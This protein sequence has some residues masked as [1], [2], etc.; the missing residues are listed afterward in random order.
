MTVYRCTTDEC[1]EHFATWSEATQ[2]VDDTGHAFTGVPE[3]ERPWLEVAYRVHVAVRIGERRDE[4]VKAALE[5]AGFAVGRVEALKS[6]VV[7]VGSSGMTR[8]EAERIA[9][10]QNAAEAVDTGDTE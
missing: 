7:G 2:H 8:D 5:D 10:E 4:R 3:D 6:R 1:G 9:T